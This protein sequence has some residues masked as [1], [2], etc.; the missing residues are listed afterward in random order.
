MEGV[1]TRIDHLPV[2]TSGGLDTQTYH[3]SGRQITPLEC[4]VYIRNSRKFIQR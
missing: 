4:N 3:L 2:A 1:Y